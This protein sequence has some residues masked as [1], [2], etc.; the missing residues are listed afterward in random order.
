MK[1]TYYEEA[2]FWDVQ[3]CCLVG[4]DRRFRR[5]NYLNIYQTTQRNISEDG[6]IHSYFPE[7]LNSYLVQIT[8]ISLYNF[9]HASFIS[10]DICSDMN[11]II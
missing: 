6:H 5:A 4:I 9:V 7:N 1:S 11:Y 3:L 8:N 10:K 2:L